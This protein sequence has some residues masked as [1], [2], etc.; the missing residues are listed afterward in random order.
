[1]LLL[2][3][4]A[5]FA[6]GKKGDTVLVMIG[7]GEQDA[8]LQRA[9]RELGISEWVYFAGEQEHPHDFYRLFDAFVFPSV[10]EGLGNV[11]CEAMLHG[12]PVICA[13]VPPMN[14][15]I[16][17]FNTGLLVP[18]DDVMALSDA[19]LR[20]FT[21]RELL[22]GLGRA[23]QAFARARFDRDQQLSKLLALASAETISNTLK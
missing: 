7:S 3:A 16:A 12:L 22:G 13:D 15:Y 17:S 6:A 11:W 14:D 23:G 10:R 21:D 8:A 1:M 20:L 2:Q 9:A 18:P 4:F 5:Q 19:M